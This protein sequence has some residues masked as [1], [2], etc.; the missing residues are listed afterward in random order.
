M[1]HKRRIEYTLLNS[2]VT[3]NNSAAI[4]IIIIVV[5]VVYTKR[6]FHFCYWHN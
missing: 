5:V 2:T 4:I 6:H 3:L 1:S